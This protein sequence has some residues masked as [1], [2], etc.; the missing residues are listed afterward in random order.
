[1]NNTTHT[2]VDIIIM[3]GLAKAG[4]R[5]SW[6]AMAGVSFIN[7]DFMNIDLCGINL[8]NCSFHN[9]TFHGTDL[10][11]VYL[12]NTTFNNCDLSE[13]V[14]VDEEEFAWSSTLYRTHGYGGARY[15]NKY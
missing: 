12:G 8:S 11:R 10:S 3:A 15:T 6:G 13:A 2:A 7:V 5:E 9:C 14:G 4:K 1:M